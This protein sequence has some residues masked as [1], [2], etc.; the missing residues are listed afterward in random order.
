[1]PGMKKF[2]ASK[3]SIFTILI[4]FFFIVYMAGVVI[5]SMIVSTPVLIESISRNKFLLISSLVILLAILFL[6][7]YNLGQVIVDRIKNKEGAKLRFRLTMYFLL[8]AIIPIIPLSVVSNNLISKSINL[9]FL[10]GIESSLLDAIEVSKE[11][12][13]NMVEESK[14][15]VMLKFSDLKKKLEN[16]DSNINFNRLDYIYLFDYKS[17]KIKKLY[18]KNRSGAFPL[19][20]EDVLSLKEKKWIKRSF[21]K[22][23]YLL[24]SI[25]TPEGSYIIIRK[26]PDRI[27]SYTLAISKGLQRYRTLKI[28]R[29]PIKGMIILFYVVIT[30]P[31]LLLS[32]Y[33]SLFISKEITNPIRELVI[34]TEKVAS[35]EL[36]YRVDIESKDELKV[37]IDSFNSM[38]EELRINRELIKYSERSSAWQDIARKLAHEIKNPLT[39]IKLSA[40]RM[41]KQYKRDDDYKKILKKGISTIIDEVNSINEMVSEF[42]SFARLPSTKMEKVNIVETI[43][44]IVGFLSESYKGIK[45]SFSYI[46]SPVFLFVDKNQFRR[47]VLNIIYNSINAVSP[48]GGKINIDISYR[49]KDK[50]RV[51]ISITDNGTGI[52]EE[53]KDKI[54]NPY[55]SKNGKG[56]GLGLAIVEKI[57]YDNKGRIWFES[58]PGKTT[59]YMEFVRA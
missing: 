18:S 43:K 48:D 21:D 51:V 29:K 14:R 59:F 54:F 6:V 41:L 16:N 56:S 23:E 17:R 39:P 20:R 38:I 8:V 4:S 47:A 22:K 11:L 49:Q 55:F 35:N 36:D 30:L 46:E 40:E 5:L 42:S 31:F 28:I 44:Q 27:V 37:L 13:G 1:M 25:N 32:F 24:G 2:I 53:I 26:V 57:I 9:W 19:K 34:A 50:N 33:L 52:D 15:E 3:S 45:F 58:I 10:S 7:I 12:Y